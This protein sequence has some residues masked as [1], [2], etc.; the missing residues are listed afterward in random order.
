[1]GEAFCAGLAFEAGAD[2]SVEFDRSEVS[3]GLVVGHAD[4]QVVHEGQDR[5]LVGSERC[6]EVVGL[7]G[8]GVAFASGGRFG[9][10]SQALGDQIVVAGGEGSAQDRGEGLELAGS[11]VVAGVVDLD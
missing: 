1:M 8:Q 9:V 2:L 11:G 3:F 4:G 10:G 6:G 5:F 7:A